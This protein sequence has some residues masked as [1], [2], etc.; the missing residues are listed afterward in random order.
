MTVVE[1]IGDTSKSPGAHALG[2][3]A[4]IARSGRRS[5]RGRG[6]AAAVSVAVLC[7]RV[8]AGVA[9]EAEQV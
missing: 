9:S 8:G 2:N 3:R 6:R 4:V 5:A 1:S 7:R